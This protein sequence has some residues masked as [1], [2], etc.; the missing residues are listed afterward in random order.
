MNIEVDF[1]KNDRL[2][3][4]KT[5]GNTCERHVLPFFGSDHFYVLKEQKIIPP[6]PV[7]MKQCKRNVLHI[8]VHNL[9]RMLRNVETEYFLLPFDH[10]QWFHLI[11]ILVLLFH[12][13]AQ[14]TQERIM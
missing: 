7:V 6:P 8:P 12:T 5:V 11:C 10:F 1:R 14:C 4:M 3:L 13:E 2:H 9:D